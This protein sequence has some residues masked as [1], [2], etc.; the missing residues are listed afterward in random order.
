MKRLFVVALG[1]LGCEETPAAVT[2]K[3]VTSLCDHASTTKSSF[4]LVVIGSGGPVSVGRAASSY[5][6]RV[7]GIPRVLVDVGPGA[8][9]RLGEAKV[10]LARV[11]TVLLTHLHVDHSGDLPGFVKSR[12][13]ATNDDLRFRIFGPSG[14]PPYPNT[15]SFVEQLFGEK[16]N[17]AYLPT[18]RNKLDIQTKDLQIGQDTPIQELVKDDLH[19]T[20][21]AVDHGK[22]PAV[23]YRIEHAGH[24]IVVSGDL[25]SKNDNLV[26]LAANADVLVYDTSVLDPPGSPSVLYD[27]HTSPRRIGEVGQAAHVRQ[28]VLGHIPPQVDQSKDSVL[29]SVQSQFEGSI[30]LAEDCLVVQ[31][32]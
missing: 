10:D 31:A 13:L 14:S 8:F 26:R 4:E 22:I 20:A 28:I 7:D 6:V 9:V 23:A 16:G 2:P 21:I 12:D 11:D 25:A 15:T 29:H 27:L 30:R 1:L 32:D 18:F 17:F 3:P 19:I 5:L 24:A